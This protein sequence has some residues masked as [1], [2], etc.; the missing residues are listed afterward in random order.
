MFDFASLNISKVDTLVDVGAGVGAFLGP[1]LEFYKPLRF[2]AIEML[3]ERAAYLRQRFSEST[4][5]WPVAVGECHT[6]AVPIRRT[7]S[8]DSSSLLAIDPRS[9]DW[10]TI[11]PHAMDQFAYGN[12]AVLTLDEIYEIARLDVIDL[13]KMDI[14]GYE[15]RAIRGGPNCLRHTRNLIIEVLFVH[16]Y[17]GQSTPE[18][19]QNELYILGFRF[20]RWLVRDFKGDILLQGDALYVNTNL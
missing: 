3:P 17:E 10:F 12:T 11:G 8:A 1:A 5:I 7:V 20:D 2:V 18:E 14:Q 4:G 13:M 15:G 6:F 19:I 16:H 9:Q